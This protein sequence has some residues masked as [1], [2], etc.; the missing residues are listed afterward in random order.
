MKIIW[1]TCL[2]LPIAAMIL[3]AVL[4]NPAAAQ[5]FCAGLARGCFKGAFQGQDAHETVPPAATTVVLT[6]YLLNTQAVPPVVLS[7]AELATTRIFASIGISVKWQVGTAHVE[8]EAPIE[9]QLDS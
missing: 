2:Y 5:T 7:K 8:G 3:T 1:R 4:A 6:L 9:I